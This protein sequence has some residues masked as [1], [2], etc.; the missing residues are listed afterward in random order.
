MTTVSSSNEKASLPTVSSS[1]EKASLPVVVII[2]G[3]FAGLSA[4]KALDNA[5]VKVILIDRSRAARWLRK[6]SLLNMTT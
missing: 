4:A 2:G 1:N 6:T 3:G 5:P